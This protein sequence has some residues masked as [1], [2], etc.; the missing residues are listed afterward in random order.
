MIINTA[1]DKTSFFFLDVFL[2]VYLVFPML[3]GPNVPTSRVIPVIFDLVGT[4][5]VL[6]RKTQHVCV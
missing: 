1:M 4:F 5:L 3:W 6:M 2:Y